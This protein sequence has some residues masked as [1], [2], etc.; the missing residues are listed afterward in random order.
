MRSSSTSRSTRADARALGR[1]ARAPNANRRNPRRGNIATPRRA[2]PA[3]ALDKKR[4]SDEEY[5]AL[6]RELSSTTLAHGAALS[7]Y[8]LLGYGVAPGLSAALGSAGALGYLRLLQD[9]VDGVSESLEN[10]NVS[11]A[12][13]TRNL[14]YEPVTDVGAMLSGAFGKVGGVYSRALLQRRLLVPTALVV[15]T[16]CWNRL[17][18]PFDFSYGATFCGFLCYK[19]AVLA[20]TWDI[21]KPLLLEAPRER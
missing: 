18:L 10:G 11:E 2:T 16:A 7:A 8:C 15:F 17:D 6:K 13:Y 14:V 3:D 20:K 12:D 1:A 19:T 5:V 9:Y 4:M 21:L